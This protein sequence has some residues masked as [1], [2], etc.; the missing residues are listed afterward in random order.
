MAPPCNIQRP[1]LTIH[2]VLAIT[3]SRY[4]FIDFNFSFILYSSRRLPA[5]SR[6]AIRPTNSTRSLEMT[7]EKL[8]HAQARLARCLAVI[9]H[10]WS[11][12]AT[13]DPACRSALS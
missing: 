13:R 6:R 8:L 11:G 12:L 3:F 4:L 10:Q 5:T 7:I 2:A 1:T 9:F